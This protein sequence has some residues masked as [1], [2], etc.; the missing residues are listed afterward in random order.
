[1]GGPDPNRN[2]RVRF[3]RRSHTLKVKAHELAKLCDADVYLVIKH[4][5]GSFVY[6]S[7]GDKSWPPNDD[8]LVSQTVPKMGS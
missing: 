3:A 2:S 8:K 1:M 5:R 7:V 6:N 4:Q